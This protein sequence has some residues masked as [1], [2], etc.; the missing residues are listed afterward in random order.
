MKINSEGRIE[1]EEKDI[2]DIGYT[3]QDIILDG[4]VSF[5]EGGIQ[6]IPLIA[7]IESGADLQIDNEENDDKAMEWWTST[8][9]F[10]I[11]H[12][13]DDNEPTYEG[14]LPLDL[15]G[16]DQLDDDPA[17]I[18]YRDETDK[19]DRNKQEAANLFGKIM[20]SLWD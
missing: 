3:L 1:F 18:E 10:I 4:L 11:Y 14:E 12:F 13:N 8:I 7:F 17:W 15:T 16:F 2:W 5:R 20:F 6:S 9:D 19:W